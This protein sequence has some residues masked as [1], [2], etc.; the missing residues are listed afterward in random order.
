[1]KRRDFVKASALLGASGLIGPGCSTRN[2]VTTDLRFD[3]HPFLQ[4]HPEAVFINR[5]SVRAK[6]DITEIRR[7]G[8]TLAREL[9]VRTFGYGFPFTAQVNLKPNWTCA[10]PENGKPVFEKLGINTDPNFVE[11]WT[12]GM[13]TLGPQNFS[14]RECACPEF[15]PAMGWTAMCERNGIDFRNLVATNVWEQKEGRDYIRWDIPDGVVFREIAYMAPMTAPGS[16]LVNIAKLKTHTMG[17]TATIKNLQ[18]IAGKKLHEFCT[19]YNRIRKEYDPRLFKYFQPDFE[20]RIEEL[21][22]RHVSDGIP[23]WDR[24]GEKGGILQEQW[25]QR[26]LDSVGKIPTALNMVEG[27]Y[28]QDGNA[29]GKGPHEPLGPSGVTSRD[30]LS[31]VILFG[32]DMFRVDII[33]FWLAGHEPG[34]FGLFHIARERGMLD[35]LDPRDIPLYEWREGKAIPVKMEDLTRT[36]LVTEYLRRDYDG[37]SEPEYHLCDEPFDYSPFRN[38]K[39]EH[40]LRPSLRYLGTDGNG[41]AVFDLTLGFHGDAAVDILDSRGHTVAHL[42]NQR[43]GTGSHHVIWDGFAKPG[44]Y[45]ARARGRGW[46]TETGMTIRG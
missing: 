23:R 1:M 7:A 24:P 6:D 22:A 43:L 5:T 18:G 8:S 13:K 2:T 32:K 34:N 39:K 16:F 15:W 19:R 41:R 27:I 20:R 45:I 14:I 33:A 35:V 46:E 38:A 36:P 4:A 10:F 9:I 3:I 26:T 42:L 21:Y 11:G 40:S 29:F 17:V 12:Q 30:Y 37:Q 44:I 31:N 25:A 28:S